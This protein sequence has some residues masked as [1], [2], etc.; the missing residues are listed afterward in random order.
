MSSKVKFLSRAKRKRLLE[1]LSQVREGTP[2]A[3]AI[4]E[5]LGAHAPLDPL[6]EAA[7]KKAAEEAAEAARKAAE[8]E[9]RKAAEAEAR[10]KREI[11]EAKKKAKVTSKKKPAA[12][13][14][15]DKKK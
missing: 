6:K 9:A 1:E 8:A 13:K 10:K 12:K 15:T 5:Q 14:T 7:K 3:K 2:E 4:R 11:A